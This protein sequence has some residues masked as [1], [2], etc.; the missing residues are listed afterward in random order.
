MIFGKKKET[1]ATLTERSAIA[2]AVLDLGGDV[3]FLDDAVLGLLDELSKARPKARFMDQ[4]PKSGDP[5]VINKPRFRKIVK[6][7]F[8]SLRE[9]TTALFEKKLWREG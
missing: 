2:Q 3:E 1:P 8:P 6:E 5:I 7:C 4:F 9:S